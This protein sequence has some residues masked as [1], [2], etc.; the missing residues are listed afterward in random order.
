MRKKHVRPMTRSGP[1]L[2]QVLRSA[3]FQM[4][5]ETATEAMKMIRNMNRFIPL[6]PRIWRGHGSPPSRC[7]EPLSCRRV[8]V[9]WCAGCNLR[10]AGRS[11]C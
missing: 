10:G 9:I 3:L 7:V 5:Y 2:L 4:K 1:P 8:I 6:L 11:E